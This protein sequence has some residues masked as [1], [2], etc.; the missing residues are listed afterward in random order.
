MKRI[1]SSVLMI[2]MLLF[3][4]NVSAASGDNFTIVTDYSKGITTL[5]LEVGTAYADRWVNIVILN[6]GYSYSDLTNKTE[7]AVNWALQTTVNSDGNIIAEMKLVPTDK[8]DD[9]LYTAVVAVD[10]IN[11][12]FTKTFNLYNDNYT[13]KVL[14][15]LK[16]AVEAS[17]KAAVGAV[18]TDYKEVTDVMNCPEYAVYTGLDTAKQ[19]RV[20][21]GIIY[22]NPATLLEFKSCFITCVQTVTL[23]SADP[24]EQYF[25]AVV[26]LIDDAA[27]SVKNELA[28]M[29]KLAEKEA[30]VSELKKNDYNSSAE[31]LERVNGIIVLDSINS[32][33]LWT[34]IASIYDK[35]SDALGIDTAAY[36]SLDGKQEA[37]TTLLGCDFDSMK[38]A[39]RAYDDAVKAQK[40]IDELES[41][42]DSSGGVS[43]SGVRG[44]K[45]SSISISAPSENTGNNSSTPIFFDLAGFEWAKDDILKLSNAGIINGFGNNT[46]APSNKITR[47]ELVKIIVNAFKLQKKAVDFS[48]DDVSYDAWYY[49]CVNTAYSCDV[50]NGVSAS[51][52]APEAYITREDMAVILCRCLGLDGADAEF[53]DAEDIS[54]YA[55][56]AVGALSQMGFITGKGDGKFCPKDNATR[57]EVAVMVARILT[58]KEAL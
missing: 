49:D 52:F 41:D 18:I 5:S 50:I 39:S 28:Y 25:V 17:D 30:F 36:N 54:D 6:P 29:T 27:A 1:I 8:S 43:S 56:S 46:F 40:I 38:S 11:D 3:T 33:Q 20:C 15:S 13:N 48:F 16:T 12:V 37:M 23:D 35:Y 14:A 31:L 2:V 10:C 42:N 51:S 21:A 32:A 4:V 53:A 57:A 34:E 24:T 55:K 45:G 44:N 26:S 22:E 58:Y 7:A 9:I 47:A 19:E